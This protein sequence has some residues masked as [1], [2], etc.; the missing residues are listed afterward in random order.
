MIGVLYNKHALWVGA[1]YSP[2]NKRWC[3]NSN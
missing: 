3:I 1:H 2:A